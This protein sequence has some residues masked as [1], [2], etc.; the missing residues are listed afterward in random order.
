MD[1]CRLFDSPSL[2]MWFME[3]TQAAEGN[4]EDVWDRLLFDIMAEVIV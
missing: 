1:L 2:L 3:T 4:Y